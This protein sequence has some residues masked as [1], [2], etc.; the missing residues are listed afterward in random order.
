MKLEVDLP[1]R[2]RVG[3]VISNF[4]FWLEG[5]ELGGDQGRLRVEATYG[6]ELRRATSLDDLDT[7]KGPE[8]GNFCGLGVDE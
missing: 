8:D 4:K 5:G 3:L 1:V 6:E 2:S 7:R